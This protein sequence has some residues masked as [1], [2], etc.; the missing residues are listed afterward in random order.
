MPTY[1]RE[2]TD[3]V[4]YDRYMKA[5]TKIIREAFDLIIEKKMLLSHVARRLGLTRSTLNMHSRNLKIIQAVTYTR[6]P[7]D[8]E[9]MAQKK[10][11]LYLGS[12]R[13]WIIRSLRVLDE[14]ALLELKEQL[15]HVHG[16]CL[17]GHKMRRDIWNT[18]K[19]DQTGWYCPEC[20][21][22]YP[23]PPRRESP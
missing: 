21:S 4:L 2:I 22:H 11:Q 5:Q 17:E 16:V 15:Q 14:A 19:G 20:A 9:K 1:H 7:A 12:I 8:L 13:G 18:E 3:R 23:D 6:I 10:H